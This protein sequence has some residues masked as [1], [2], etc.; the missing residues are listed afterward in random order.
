[1]VRGGRVAAAVIAVL[2]FA[3]ACAARQV[4]GAQPPARKSPKPD[5]YEQLQRDLRAIFSAPTVDHGV[6]S[7]AV[8]S[9]RRGETLYSSNSFR[10]Q[11]PASN[12]KVLTTAVAADRLGWDYRYT[13]RLYATGPISSTGQLDGDLVVVSNGDPTINPRHELRWAAFDEWAKQLAA[14]GVRIINGRL[15]G[16]DNAFAEPGWGLGW[17]WDDFVF[18]YGAPVSAL[19]YH[20]NQVEL[21]IGPGLAAGQRAIIS[22]SPPG[23][24]L[25]LDHAVI[26]A[27]AGAQSQVSF[28]R[29]PGSAVIRVSGQVAAEAAPI[30]ETAAVPNPTTFYLNG[31]HDALGRHGIAVGGPVVDIDD[32]P[33]VPDATKGMLLLEDRSASLFEIVD[34]TNKWSRNLYAETLL[35][36]LSPAGEPATTEAG[37]KVLTETLR[38]W[39]VSSNYYLARDGS[40]LSRYDYL[41]PDALIGALTYMWRHP[42]LADNFRSS[43]PLA[44]Q[45]GSLANRLKGTP[46]EAR[47]WAKTGSMSQVR[48]LAGYVMTAEGEPLAF[49]FM[50]NGFRVPTREID[51]A[52]DQALLRLVAFKH[53]SPRP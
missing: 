41:S 43:L 31:L 36:S 23:S 47:V 9:L 46:A 4:T 45:S 7:V 53:P 11:V 29:I 13:T 52:I 3:S 50:V 40:G 18:G 48:S 5:V 39:G 51:A 16:D 14:R 33:V 12:Q 19:Q 17:S 35:R 25:T 20:E 15:I 22:V 10:L 42:A 32:L 37:L 44:G 24:G 27:P 49:A 34:V 28:E 21:L 1:M 30:R 6:W 2:V 38:G 26:T 8:H